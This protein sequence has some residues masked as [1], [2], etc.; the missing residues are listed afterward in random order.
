MTRSSNQEVLQQVADKSAI[1]EVIY[2]YGDCVD[3]GDFGGVLQCFHPDGTFQYLQDGTPLPVREFFESQADAGAGMRETMHHTMNVLIKVDGD[4][5]RAQ[6]YVLAH[7]WLPGDC[8]PYPPLFPQTGRE[9]GVLL[10]ARYQDR[11]ERRD[12]EWKIL[13]R[14]LHF[15]WDAPIP[16][17]VVSGP[18]AN[19][20]GRLASRP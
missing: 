9:Y 4:S 10:G 1:T 16:A 15:E 12:G 11:F 17:P 5:A 14:T 7:H 8:P 6:S 3:R 20:R 19:N 18:L 2:T 13:Q